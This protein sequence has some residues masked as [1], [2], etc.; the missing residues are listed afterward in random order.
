[1]TS[2]AITICYILLYI[3][4]LIMQLNIKGI[5]CRKIITNKLMIIFDIIDDMNIKYLRIENFP[6]SL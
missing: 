2:Y 5:W 6:E 3:R 4:T 1:M